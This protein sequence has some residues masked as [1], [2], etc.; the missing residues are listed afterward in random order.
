VRAICVLRL[1]FGL[2]G[3]LIA[4]VAFGECLIPRFAASNRLKFN[5]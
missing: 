4:F 3:I 2:L 5:R 1:Y